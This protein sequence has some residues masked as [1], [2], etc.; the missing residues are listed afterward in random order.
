[1][2][3]RIT[4]SVSARRLGQVGADA[5][6]IALAYYL[7]FVLRFDSGIPER[8]QEL[9]KVTLAF[10]IVLKLG[11]FA[12]FGLYSKLWRFVDQADFESIVKAV[13]TSSVVLIVGLFLLP[14]GVSD[15]PRGVMALDLLLTLALV[16]GARFVV[17][18]VVER[19]LR[20]P[21]VQRAS[22]EV[23][24]V[25]AGN[26]G[27][28]VAVELRRNPELSSAV[29][30]FV[31]DDPRKKGMLVAGYRVY[32][33]TDDLPRILD[34][35]HPDE[36]VIAIPSASGSL[37]LKVV[38]ACR[39]RD[40]PVRTLPT[41]FELL[42]RGPNLLRQVREVKV[43]DVLGREPV[44][45][46]IERVGAYLRDRVVVVTGA[47]GS[48]G[49][50]L[51]RQIARVKPRRLVL[52]DHAENNLFEI[53]RQLEEEHH[54]GSLAAVLADC[55]D[56]TRMA[57]LFAEEQP[58]VVFHAAAYKHV[59]LMEENP[60]EAVR[61]NA[62]ATRIVA[63]AAGEAGVERFVLVSTDKAVSPATVMGAS[64][65]LAEWAVE[66]AQNRYR[67]TRYASVRFGNVLGSSGSV[68]PIFRRQIEAGGPVTVTDP[69][70]TRYFM[71]IP[72]AVQLI[73]NAADL[74][75]L[76]P[77]GGPEIAGR[78]EQ[79]AP[80][81]RTFVLEMGDPVKIVDL[82]RNMIRLSGKEPDVDIAIEVIGRRP[83]E[84]IH[85]DLFEAGERPQ[86]TPAERIVAAV[87]P[88][89]DPE[90]VETAFAR[91]EDLVFNGDAAALADAV[92]QLSAERALTNAPSDPATE[93]WA[94]TD[95]GAA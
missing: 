26:G 61:N 16:G 17:R 4:S 81:A 20:Q 8:Y 87:R 7:A 53:R 46:E 85:E 67:A 14:F 58:S 90:W 84:K 31:D 6:L 30:G 3:T 60:V 95:P 13:V 69:E 48:I 75:P 56:A 23:L 77:R 55:K 93:P 40:I 62:V 73:I 38:T 41:V 80:R 63:A 94:L 68:V 83:G 43:E 42:S 19:P 12:A 22:S 11:L 33:T 24:I 70:M 21:L 54:F 2:R 39:E 64:K 15:P 59:G 91:I 9:L 88:R 82:A 57:E 18:A 37:R 50:E 78:D 34:D 72:E 47:G 71:T 35:T 51:C 44:R 79:P 32:G 29:I 5:C 28:Q 45:A 92:A 49:S 76:P 89:L 65:A 52:V 74:V 25:G 86:P 1:M 10:V 66:A 36:V 27:Q